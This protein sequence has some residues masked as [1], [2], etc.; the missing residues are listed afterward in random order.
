MPESFRLKL[1]SDE[2]GTF[3]NQTHLISGKASAGPAHRLQLL[4][5]ILKSTRRT[6]DFMVKATRAVESGQVP[7]NSNFLPA[8]RELEPF[9]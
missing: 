7:N 4:D 3:P 6:L 2:I 1:L 5:F 9:A 8:H